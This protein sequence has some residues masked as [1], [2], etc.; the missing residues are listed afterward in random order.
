MTRRQYGIRA[1]WGAVIRG[2]AS[3]KGSTYHCRFRAVTAVLKVVAWLPF[4]DPE[5]DEVASSQLGV[6]AAAASHHRA[7]FSILA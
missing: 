5:R 7:C 4:L 2:A 3:S 6:D 1:G